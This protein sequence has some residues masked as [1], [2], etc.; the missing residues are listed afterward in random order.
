MDLKQIV[1]NM[2]K[3]FGS[4]EFAGEA[5]VETRR[6]DGKMKVLSR[7]YHL[8]SSVQ[9]AD[10]VM[11]TIPAIAGEIELDYETKVKL[12][13]PKLSAEGYAIGESGFTNYVLTA[14]SIVKA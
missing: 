8:Y 14:D 2:E 11:V 6:E 13:E 3:T 4:L 9:K 12:V 10:Q 1:P 5:S 7:T